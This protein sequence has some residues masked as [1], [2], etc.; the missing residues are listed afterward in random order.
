L[1]WPEAP[2]IRFLAALAVLAAPV[3]AEMLQGADDPAFRAA[4]TTL[5]AT[6]D[7][8]AVAALRDLAEDGNLAARVTLPLAL[9]WVPPTG[10]LK[11]KNAQRRVGGVN[12]Q[13]AATLAHE[14]T[15]L[16]N[17]GQ[18]DTARDLPDRAARL[19][20]L[21]EPEKAATLLYSWLNQTGGSSELPAVILSD[22]LPAM[23][24]ALALADRL[25]HAV[26]FNGD[27]AAEAARLL[28]ALREDRLSAW[29]AYVHLL[30]SDRE[31]FDIVGS[32]LA[33][34]G[35]SAAE[36]D[37]RIADA[38][39]VR[40]VWRAFVVGEVPTP[41]ATVLRAREVLQG[42]AELAPIANLCEAHCPGST[43]SCQAAVLAY[44]GL[45]HSGVTIL[46]PFTDV[47][48]P[49]DYAASDRGIFTLIRPRRDPASATD[50]ATAE[51]LDACYGKLLARRDSLSF[52][53]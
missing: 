38:R 7:P 37:S 26:F 51:S 42:R 34:T 22:D 52:G 5:L 32:P 53:P 41:V 23:L 20:A 27:P 14:P 19:L 8:A 30:D 44:P 1:P 39:A 48:D 4:L 46:L 6:D 33:G 25:R 21:G 43:A 35:L 11:E 12:A 10:N 47:L 29:V 36:T 49:A 13:D 24:G 31:I 50:R 45:I 18:F 3:E 17:M 28:S 16:W 2:L 9:Q 40:A 15:A